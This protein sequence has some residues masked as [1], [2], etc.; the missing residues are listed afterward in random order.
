[1]LILTGVD[2][3]KEPPARQQHR[4]REKETTPRRKREKREAVQTNAKTSRKESVEA[5]RQKPAEMPDG[6][7]PTKVSS[8]EEDAATEPVTEASAHENVPRMSP[9]PV[10][11][12]E[13]PR[14]YDGSSSGE[15]AM[16][17]SMPL[18]SADIR[19]PSAPWMASPP[20]NV[21][22]L[23]SSSLSTVSSLHEV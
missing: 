13:E 16:M 22:S 7:R 18:G 4:R 11:V 3:T 1:V 8:K 14:S 20:D 5:C 12:V 15:K 9:M 17:L 10:P 21:R 2:E 19:R 23:S 6:P